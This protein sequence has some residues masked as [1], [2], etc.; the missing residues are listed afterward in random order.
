MSS[1]TNSEGDVRKNLIENDLVDCMVALPTQLL[2]S[3]SPPISGSWQ[4][5]RPMADRDRSKH[6]LFIDAR[7]IGTMISRRQKELTEDDISRIGE[8]FHSWR[9]KEWEQKYKDVPGLCKSVSI[10]EIRKNNHFLT[11]G[12]YID[13]SEEKDD[14]E[15]FEEKMKN[16]TEALREQLAKAHDLDEQIR[17]NLITIGYEI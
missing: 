14:G 7:E 4:G 2:I 6:V 15:L 12:R 8:T 5:I 13:S 9:S 16:L 10:D 11:P 1:D 17:Q 3:R